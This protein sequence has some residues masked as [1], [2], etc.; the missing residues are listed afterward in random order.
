MKSYNV[1]SIKVKSMDSTTEENCGSDIVMEIGSDFSSKIAFDLVDGYETVF[2]FIENYK[3]EKLIEIFKKYD[4]LVE[5]K[6]IT[7]DVLFGF[8]QINDIECRE[9]FNKLNSDFLLGN[10]SIDIILDKINKFGINSLS[11][12]DKKLLSV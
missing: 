5:Y 6:D 8:N 7:E 1:Y 12:I 11:D 10:L 9:T 3:C 2:C 4:V